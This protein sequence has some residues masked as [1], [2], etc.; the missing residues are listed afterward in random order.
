MVAKTRSK[1]RT[2]VALD[3]EWITL[4]RNGERPPIEPEQLRSKWHAAVDGARRILGREFDIFTAG[5]FP[6]ED[7][8]PRVVRVHLSPSADN[9]LANITPQW[10]RL[11]RL[12]NSYLLVPNASNVTPVVARVRGFEMLEMPALSGMRLG[13]TAEIIADAIRLV[14]G[15]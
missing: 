5:R 14:C 13:A 9:P 12:P 3:A 4:W 6:Q 15:Q 10:K 7:R 1:Q 2:R 8:D 11:A